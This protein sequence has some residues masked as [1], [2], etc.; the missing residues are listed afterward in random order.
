[1][2]P[3]YPDEDVMKAAITAF[4][5]HLWYFFEALI[6]FGFFDEEASIEEKGMMVISGAT[7]GLGGA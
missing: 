5:C 1:L 6:G 7:N 2:L 4:G 3:V